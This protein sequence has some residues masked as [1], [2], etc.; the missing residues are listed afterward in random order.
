MIHKLNKN[1]LIIILVFSCSGVLDCNLVNGGIFSIF[2]KSQKGE[3]KNI[4][5]SSEI[6]AYANYC[7]AVNMMLEN[8]WKDAAMYLAKT[9]E[10]DPF[11]EM[12][13]LYLS[14][15]YF[16]LNQNE[17][18]IAHL[19]DAARIKPEEFDIH[20]TLGNIFQSSNKFDKAIAEFELAIGCKSGNNNHHI[21]YGDT[22]L[23]LAD[24]YV[25]KND[26]DKAISCLKAV[27]DLNITNDPSRL[28]YEI[29]KLYYNNGDIKNA[30]DTF[31][32]AKDANPLIQNV[33]PYLATCYEQ[34]GKL[35]DAA[36]AIKTFL[37]KS[38][39]AWSMHLALYRIYN[40][41]DDKDLANDHLQDA[42]RI[43]NESITL[44]S[45]EPD[46]YI[47]LGQIFLNKNEEKRAL[48][49]LNKCL[50]SC[51]DE[52][53]KRDIH[54]LLSNVYYEMNQFD[55]VEYE[56]KKTLEID[57]NL[58]QANNFL[59]Y[60]YA[61]RG[62]NLDEAIMLIQKALDAEPENAAYLDSLGWVYFM[63]AALDDKEDMVLLALEKLLKAAQL[64]NDPEIQ[65]HIGNVYFSLGKWNKAEEE[66]IKALEYSNDVNKSRS[67]VKIAKRLKEK[68]EKLNNL[69]FSEKL[70]K[71]ILSNVKQLNVN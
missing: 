17:L 55:N 62:R 28:Y 69:K 64:S 54:F 37:G 2:Q 18:A 35:E 51:E 24:L 15:C 1:I 5:A 4:S 14:S 45:K 39:N 16:Q 50:L 65:E 61:E 30:V 60:F 68:I 6:K 44:G 12:A 58:H 49:V 29:G 43:L 22:L 70:D 27:I 52:T 13:H 57:D 41:I 48:A 59:G 11:S 32:T 40:K 34:L 10:S 36:F 63:K 3:P 8:R 66:W 38:P 46:E 23:K 7:V 56:L 71:K 42:I 47:T 31:E 25:G 19:E 33:Y 67:N 53:K 21:L 9:V 20:Y 26:I